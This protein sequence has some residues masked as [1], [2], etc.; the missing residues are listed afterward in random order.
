MP[1]ACFVRTASRATERGCSAPAGSQR[2]S[3]TPRGREDTRKNIATVRLK[4]DTTTDGAGRPRGS[5]AFE[6]SVKASYPKQAA[7]DMRERARPS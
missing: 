2:S 3:D 1:A 7:G 4:P 6:P 5:R